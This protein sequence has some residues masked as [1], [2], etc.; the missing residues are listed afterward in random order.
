MLFSI[1]L[2]NW[3]VI[4]TLRAVEDRERFSDPRVDRYGHLCPVS[5]I[6]ASFLRAFLNND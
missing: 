6:S 2:P 5:T 3:P 4:N 1:S